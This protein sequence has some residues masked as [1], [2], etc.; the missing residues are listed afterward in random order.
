MKSNSLMLA[1]L[2]VVVSAV[3]LCITHWIY[4]W[5]NPKC[6]GKLPPGSMG[7]PLLGETIQFFAP[8]RAN[9]ISPFITKKME[10]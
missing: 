2:S 9:N 4:K 3:I 10:R 7:F 1:L 8:Y 5:R 6:N